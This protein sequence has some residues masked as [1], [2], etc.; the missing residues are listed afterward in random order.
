M[1]STDEVKGAA[2]RAMRQMTMNEDI[3]WNVCLDLFERG[4]LFNAKESSVST[5]SRRKLLVVLVELNLSDWEG[6]L[7]NAQ[8]ECF[9]AGYVAICSSDRNNRK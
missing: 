4:C 7:K 8:M 6:C 1:A 5:V 2:K 3:V 9:D